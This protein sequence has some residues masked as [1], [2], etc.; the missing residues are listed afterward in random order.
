MGQKRISALGILQIESE[1]I[2]LINIEEVIDEFSN[3]A[4]R[5]LK[6]F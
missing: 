1:N 3:R 4:N 2:D 5:H 6:F